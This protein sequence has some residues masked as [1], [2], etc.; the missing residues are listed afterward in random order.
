MKT[1]RFF[2]ASI[3][4]GLTTSC[5]LI[6]VD[7]ISTIS[8][9]GYWQSKGDV[10]S[11]LVGIYTSLRDACNQTAHFEDRGDEFVTGLE[12]GPSNMWAQNL[13]SQN[14]QGWNSYYTVIQHCNMLLKYAPQ[15]TY[16]IESE[17]NQAMAEAYFIRAYMYFCVARVWGDAP[18]EL[19]PTEGSDKPKLG[20]SPAID[21]IGR[22]LDDV[23]TA[24]SLFPEDGYIAGKSRASRPAC[25]ALKADI[26]LWRAKVLGGSEQDLKDVITYA[27]LASQ[28]LSLEE[29]FSAIYDTGNKK[30]KE[31]IFAIHFEYLE[32]DAQYSRTLKPR[33]IF[34]RNAVNK[35]QIAYSMSGTRSTYAPSDKL[36]SLLDTYPGDI[37][38]DASIITA[39]DASGN[40]I[41]IFDNKMKGTV[42]STDNRSYDCDIIIYRLAEM[43]MFKAE[44]YAAL[45]QIPEAVTE[46]NK[47]RDRA[48]I[49]QYAGAM[50]KLSVEKEILD[51]RGREFYLERKRWPDLLRFHYE[52]VIDVYEEVPNLKNKKDQGTIIPLYCAIPLSDLDR[53]HNLTQTEGS[54]KL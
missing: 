1:I 13:T 26:L 37:R 30:G 25:Y 22:A 27:D 18:I 5:G 21:V 8:G 36:I 47:V 51:E 7:T 33:E 9:D 39:V 50:D 15:V 2:L 45:G 35:D 46:L 42:T 20:R 16:G 19:E 48:R 40:T 32:K 12:G 44:A 14:G 4:L 38:K 24:I 28:G 10:D 29:D 53:N 3:L 34:V 23:D 31:V 43:Y 49:G 41:G 17:R 6:D 11:Y 52:G 54:E